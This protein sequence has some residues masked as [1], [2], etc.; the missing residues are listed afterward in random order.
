[1]SSESAQR[2]FQLR[3]DPLTGNSEWVVI[4]ENEEGP[5]S[6]KEPLLATTSYLD[7]LN[8]SSRNRAYRLAIEKTVTKPCHVLDIG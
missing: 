3:L 1:M 7:M 4:D 6:F 8:D 5:E 2:V